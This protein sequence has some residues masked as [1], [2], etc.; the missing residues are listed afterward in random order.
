MPIWIVLFLTISDWQ[1]NYINYH[2]NVEIY[3]NYNSSILHKSSDSLVSHVKV[4]EDVGEEE[5]GP[6]RLGD[7]EQVDD[8]VED[9]GPG[10]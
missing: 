1:N 5:E 6:G 3:F 2:W 10:K 9:A 7:G 4:C 8:C